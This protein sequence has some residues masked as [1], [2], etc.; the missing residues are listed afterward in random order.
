[1]GDLIGGHDDP[2]GLRQEP[3]ILEIADDRGEIVTVVIVE[4]QEQP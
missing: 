2:G 1:M 3:H 4:G